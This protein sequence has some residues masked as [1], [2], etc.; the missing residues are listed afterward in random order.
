[1]NYFLALVLATTLCGGSP[2]ESSKLTS[3]TDASVRF[4][5]PAQH[6]VELQRGGVRIVVADNSALDTGPASGH[7]AG[8]NGLALLERGDKPGNLFVPSVAGLN[9]E[10][11]HDGTRAVNKERFE[12]RV[13]PMRLRVID[14]FTVEVHQPPTPNWQ[15]ESCGRYRLLPDGVIEY[16]FECIPRADVFQQKW[17]GLFWASYIQEPEDKAI[18]FLGRP[19][20]DPQAAP[21]WLKTES[22]Q[23]GVESTHP[24]LGTLPDLKF[25]ADFSLTL[26]NHRSRFVHSEPWYF[27]VSH[28]QAL[29]QMFRPGDR[30]W[31]A[32]SPTGGGAKNPAWDF[33]WFVEKPRVGQAYGLVMRAAL[34]PYESRDQL[35]K[36]V[37]RHLQDLGIRPGQ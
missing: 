1:M 16:S 31:F 22:P 26:A 3:L 11:I 15:L 9:F 24:P 29:V 4:T 28:G 32:Q 13:A 5:E 27:G 20:D 6:F 10:H 23:H 21:R 34:V 37:A 17:L 18:Q 19:A 35:E 14:E 7:K 12:P 8:Y 36:Q 25:T 30:I 33:Q 2:N